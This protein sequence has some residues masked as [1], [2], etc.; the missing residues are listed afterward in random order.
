[1]PRGYTRRRATAVGAGARER[2]AAVLDG[3]AGDSGAVPDREADRWDGET[4]RRAGAVGTVRD[5]FDRSVYLEF[6]PEADGTLGPSLVLLCGPGFDGPLDV[7]LERDRDDPFR[8]DR[9][10][11]GDRVRLRSTDQG[12]CVLSVGPSLEVAV[13]GSHLRA[14]NEREP[15][16]IDPDDA[17]RRRSLRTLGWLVDR[18]ADGLGWAADLLAT[19]RGDRSGDLPELADSWAGAIGEGEPERADLSL[20]GRGPGATPS[21]DDVLSGALVVLQR[22]GSGTRRRRVRELGER[23]VV[24][25]EGR[26]TAVSGALLAQAAVGR[27]TG[28]AEE[29]VG[30][31]LGLPG[32]PPVTDAAAELAGVGHT[33]GGDM[34]VGMLAALLLVGPALE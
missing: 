10:D 8:P 16:V 3:R 24:A 7:R 15:E 22:T 12:G 4:D 17:V 23:A 26:T 5:P 30:A 2:L 14:G 9:L 31:L 13:G 20:L 32:S 34:L 6:D 11:R 21:G 19:V 27:T 1:M 18:E 33:S 28:S 29:M 25:A